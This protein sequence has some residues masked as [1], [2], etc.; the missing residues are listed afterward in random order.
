MFP[1]IVQPEKHHD[2]TL[3]LGYATDKACGYFIDIIE[4][5]AVENLR[6]QIKG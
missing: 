3:W 5:V 1:K 2:V 4:L 6:K